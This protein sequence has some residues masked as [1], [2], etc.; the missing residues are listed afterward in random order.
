MT[1]DLNG[2]SAVLYTV[3][4]FG[5]PIGTTDLGF[6]VLVPEHRIGEFHPNAEGERLMPIVTET[7]AAIH[8]DLQARRPT[9]SDRT[10]A[11]LDAAEEKLALTL[12]LPDGARLPVSM[13][14]IRDMEQVVT[15]HVP[16]DAEAEEL[17]GDLSPEEREELERE[18]AAMMDAWEE[19][20][21]L[22]PWEPEPEPQGVARYQLHVTFDEGAFVP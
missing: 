8:A 10:R 15:L 5:V 17:L 7:Y 4:N 13:I 21:A 12:H 18:V 9:P 16:D 3:C 20:H 22:E 19:E 11:A 1:P 14:S 6:P 2:A